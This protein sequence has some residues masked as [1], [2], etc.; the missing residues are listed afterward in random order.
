MVLCLLLS[1]LRHDGSGCDADE[2]LD[3][4]EKVRGYSLLA[5]F[6]QG[7]V[8]AS[9]FQICG[10]FVLLHPRSLAEFLD[11]APHQHVVGVGVAAHDSAFRTCRLAVITA[12]DSEY[13]NPTLRNSLRYAVITTLNSRQ[14]YSAKSTNQF[15]RTACALT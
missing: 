15:T 12:S 1:R 9:R 11:N 2:V 10:Q 13:S 4:G 14:S 7:D 3:V 8:A 6:H 5:G